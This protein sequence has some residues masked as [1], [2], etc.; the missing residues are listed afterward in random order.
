M[1]SR[2]YIYYYYFKTSAFR[3]GFLFF[4]SPPMRDRD[5]KNVQ[6]HA[7]AECVL[8]YC[9]NDEF[10][11]SYFRQHSYITIRDEY[12]SAVVLRAPTRRAYGSRLISSLYSHCRYS[13]FLFEFHILSIPRTARGM[14]WFNTR[15]MS[16][17]FWRPDSRF[18]V[19]LHKKKLKMGNRNPSGG[20]NLLCFVDFRINKSRHV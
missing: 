6:S 12:Y 3:R 13:E 20:E 11:I 5:N 10:Y 16:L 2:E 9:S 15:A 1:K 7:Y 8:D 19:Y 17:I 4:S 18:D 14:Y